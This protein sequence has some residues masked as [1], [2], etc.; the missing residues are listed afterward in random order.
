MD[1]VLIEKININSFDNSFNDVCSDVCSGVC[2]DVCSDFVCYNDKKDK[3]LHNNNS[4]RKYLIGDTEENSILR[5]DHECLI[6][7]DSMGLSPIVKCG[8]CSKFV[9]YECYKIFSTKNNYYK[10][11]CVQCGTR[12]LQFTK[13]WWQC[14][15]CF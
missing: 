3:E 7:Y 15:C 10:M 2:L 14:W 8:I 11:K 9:H 4:L 1:D 6:C 13:K 12:S 5:V